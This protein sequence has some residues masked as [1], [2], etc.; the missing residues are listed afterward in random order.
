MF[1]F[2]FAKMKSALA[3]LLTLAIFAFVSLLLPAPLFAGKF[4]DR[5]IFVSKFGGQTKSLSDLQHVRTN[6]RNQALASLKEIPQS[7]KTELV[8]HAD[9]QMKSGHY[10]VLT[11]HDFSEFFRNGNRMH[12]QAKLHQRRERISIL[13][14]GHLLDRETNHTSMKYVDEIINGVWMLLE[15]ST[16][17]YPAHLSLQGTH[18]HLPNP[19]HVAVDLNAG[20]VAK[21]LGWVKL[22]MHEEFDKV[23]K[24]VNKRIDFELKNRIFEAYLKINF[25]WEGFGG[26]HSVNNWNIWVNGNILKSAIFTIDDHALFTRVLNKTLHSADYFL[27]GYGEDGKN[28]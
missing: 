17:C 28:F 14:I 3:L 9:T 7:V 11:A 25:G 21:F 18:D 13:L 4:H 27:D 20:E 6:V 5:K 22:L 26:H 12:Y 8:H 19:D 16:W 10:D 2:I 23:S 1:V 24:V 15:E